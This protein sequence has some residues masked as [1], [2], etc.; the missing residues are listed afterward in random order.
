MDC[1]E[2]KTNT[3]STA[4]PEWQTIP[5]AKYFHLLTFPSIYPY[6]FMDNIPKINFTLWLLSFDLV[7]YLHTYVLQ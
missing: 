2:F 1:S 3:K 6:I 7:S 4:I 5:I